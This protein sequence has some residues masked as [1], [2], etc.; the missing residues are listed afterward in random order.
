MA[1]IFEYTLPKVLKY[2]HKK[3]SIYSKSSPDLVTSDLAS[4]SR[5]I[6][7]LL[8][9]VPKDFDWSAIKT[10]SE[11][12]QRDLWTIRETLFSQILIYVFIQLIM[13]AYTRTTPLNFDANEYTFSLFGSEKTTSD[14]DVS[15]EGP[16]ASFLISILED[17][18]VALTGGSCSRWDVE[19]Y[20]D[21]LL[22]LD[23]NEE[24]SFLNSREFNDAASDI[25]PF[26]G[27]S[28]LRNTGT[29][30]FP[31]LNKF[32]AA[33][34]EV[35]EL[36]KPD[37]KTKAIALIK[38]AKTMSYDTQRETYYTYLRKAEEINKRH[39]SPNKQ[40][41]LEMFL[42]LSYANIFRSEN[43]IIPSTVI[44]I[45]RD[46]QAKS[47]KPES[48]LSPE[49]KPY[50]VRLAS[51]ALGPFTYLCS[52]MEQIGYMERFSYDKAKLEKYKERFDM[53]M[54]RYTTKGGKRFRRYTSYT[55]KRNVN[56]LRRKSVT[57]RRKRV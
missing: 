24:P 40:S 41:N 47:P 52:A 14:I 29:L 20:G 55:S 3:R 37:W 28:I 35:S 22:F 25:L 51:C 11:E 26:V 53:A 43:Y 2:Y 45:V 8:E 50:H 57:Y 46:V 39:I 10:F 30:E 6:A 38:R 9:T 16:D 23:E 17:A 27:A 18:W 15:V 32:I 49:C 56:L 21:F 5:F 36:Q 12:E 48:S 34:P 19:F 1:V 54:E 4:I 13:R 31:R 42:A 7:S 33:H 44:H